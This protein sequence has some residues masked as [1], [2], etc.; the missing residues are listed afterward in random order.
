MLL[1][2]IYIKLWIDILNKR[3]IV[4]NIN[5]Q[6]CKT[7]KITTKKEARSTKKVI[8]TISLTNATSYEQEL[9][10]SRRFVF[11]SFFFSEMMESGSDLC[12]LFDLGLQNNS[13]H[14]ADVVNPR[15][16]KQAVCNR[17]SVMCDQGYYFED[18]SFRLKLSTFIFEK[19][20]LI[21]P[22]RRQTH[23]RSLTRNTTNNTCNQVFTLVLQMKWVYFFIV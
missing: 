3:L 5:C 2:S 13:K 10:M 20:F 11:M 16:D 15:S 9:I 7:Q 18:E 21:G 4:L 14:R 8:N 6:A 12:C 1:L 19:N 22:S 17:R 23:L